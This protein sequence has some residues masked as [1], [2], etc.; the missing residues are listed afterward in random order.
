MIPALSTLKSILPALTS[1][2]AA[3]RSFVTVPLLGLGIR[4]RGPSTRPKA[5]ILPMTL[6]MVMITSMSVHPDLIL[7]MYSSRP[8]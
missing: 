3:P 2:I 7:L 6:G 4:P 5:P 1:L 8:T